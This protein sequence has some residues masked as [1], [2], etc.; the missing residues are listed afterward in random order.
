MTTGKYTRLQS[1][2][3]ASISA[4]SSNGRTGDFESPG[5]G[6]NPSEATARGVLSVRFR[7]VQRYPIR[8]R[9]ATE[10]GPGIRK[11]DRAVMC[12]PAKA[13]PVFLDSEGSIPSSSAPKGGDA[14]EG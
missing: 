10:R 5:L 11:I 14:Y 3:D 4:L 1:R 7:L 8:V 2:L 13:W 9:C 12:C 6:S